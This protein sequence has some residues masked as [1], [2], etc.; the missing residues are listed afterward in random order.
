MKSSAPRPFFNVN[1]FHAA[2]RDRQVSVGR[3]FVRRAVREGRVQHVKVGSKRLIPRTELD[4]WLARE[5]RAN[6]K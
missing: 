2:L 1:E 4:D 3:D 5:A 6:L